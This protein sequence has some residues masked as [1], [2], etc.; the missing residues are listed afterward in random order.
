MSNV[1]GEPLERNGEGCLSIV[2][3]DGEMIRQDWVTGLDAPK[4][5][6]MDGS[7]LYVT[8]IDRL[9]AIDNESG[10]VSGTWQGQG[11]IF[12]NDPA[13]AEDGAFS[14]PTCFDT[15]YMF[16]MA[17][18]SRFGWRTRPFSTPTD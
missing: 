3:L 15:R 2:S 6:A 13:V 11:A 1:A 8:D 17:T 12:L 10:I 16:S 9:V 5:I 18:V 7:M 14:C 4:G